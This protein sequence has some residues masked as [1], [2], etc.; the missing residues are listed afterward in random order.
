MD[1]EK[2]PTYIV[3]WAV[4]ILKAQRLLSRNRWEYKCKPTIHNWCDMNYHSIEAALTRENKTVT[5]LNTG[6]W[7]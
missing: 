2:I 7:K 3:Q 5:F 1:L 4:R 6:E